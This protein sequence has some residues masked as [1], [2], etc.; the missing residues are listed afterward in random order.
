PGGGRDDRGESLH[1]PA[2]AGGSGVCEG[3][4]D[5]PATHSGDVHL[6]HPRRPAGPRGLHR[7]AADI[8]HRGSEPHSRGGRIMTIKVPPRGTRGA[9]SPGAVFQFLFDPVTRMQ[10]SRYRRSRG[11]EQPRT[12]GFPALLPTTVGARTGLRRTV[13]LGGFP[14]GPAARLG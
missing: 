9:R 2:Q 11:P 3:G 14:D 6:A 5:V 12:F 4:E 13:I 1:P 10:I 7:G 8:A